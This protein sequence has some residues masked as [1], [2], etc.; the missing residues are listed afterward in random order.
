MHRRKLDT[1]GFWTFLNFLIAA[2]KTNLN[3]YASPINCPQI[4][5]FLLL[6]LL[7]ILTSSFWHTHNRKRENPEKKRF[8]LPDVSHDRA[9]K[10]EHDAKLTP[11]TQGTCRSWTKRTTM[12]CYKRSLSN[13]FSINQQITILGNYHI[14]NTVYRERNK[15]N[16]SY[17]SSRLELSLVLIMWVGVPRNVLNKFSKRKT[18]KLHRNNLSILI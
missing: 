6:L 12:N 15:R 10:G 7:Y 9:K 14:G 11:G 5:L 4:P 1:N 3:N 13:K 16:I 2:P 17:I 18:E 8:S